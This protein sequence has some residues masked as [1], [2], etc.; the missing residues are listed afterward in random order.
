MEKLDHVVQI[1]VSVI[2]NHSASLHYSCIINKQYHLCEK[3]LCT[4]SFSTFLCR[5]C[6]TTT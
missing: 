3:Q 1:A 2:L 5:H 6:T 4:Y